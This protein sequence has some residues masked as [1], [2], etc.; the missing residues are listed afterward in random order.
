MSNSQFLSLTF[1]K[2]ETECPR[3]VKTPPKSSREKN[4]QKLPKTPQKR[5]IYP[6]FTSEFFPYPK[7]GKYRVRTREKQNHVKKEIQQRR[8]KPKK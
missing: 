1:S 7:R 8:K 2:T 3:T 6:V 5:Q 4:S